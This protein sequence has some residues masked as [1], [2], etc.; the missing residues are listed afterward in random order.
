MKPTALD[1]DGQPS[2]Q[3]FNF[4]RNRDK[5]AYALRGLLQGIMADEKLDSQELLFLDAWLR[6]QQALDN[7][8]VVDLL[9]L[10]GEILEDGVI[11]HDELQEV[12]EVINAIIEFGQQSSSE[13]EAS[14]NELLGLLVGIAADGKITHEELVQL[15]SWIENNGQI[16]HQWPTNEIIR[17]ITAINEDGVVTEEE[18][19]D[20]L[21]TVKQLSGHD[22]EETGSADGG[23]AEVF[24]N[25][26]ENIVHQ[27]KTFCFTGKFV[28]GTRAAVEGSAMEKGAIISSNFTKKVDILVIGTLA[29]RDWRFTSHGRKIE[30]AL[31]LKQGGTDILILSERHWL[32]CVYGS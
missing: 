15:E 6:S 1:K 2:I 32:K 17:R 27:G 3:A 9:N 16:A 8:D 30:K 21:E 26:V 13:S 12:T 31:K 25:N 18:L 11:T 24:S 19:G 20:L 10:I 22:Y 28:C 29:S 14:I 23:V 4:S 5:A 7:G